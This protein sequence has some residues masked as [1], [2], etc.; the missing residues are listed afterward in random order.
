MN[1]QI[2]SSDKKP[3]FAVIPFDEWQKLQDRL[4]DLEDLADARAL[5]ARI[6]SGEDETFPGEF[7]DRL[8]SGEHPLT[9]W[10]EFRG[11]TSAA[12]ASACG[13][14]GPAISQIE[15]G[16]REPSASLLRRMATALRC[17]MDDLMAAD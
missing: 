11:M 12:L 5:S 15:S 3:Q 8:L 17:S 13:V 7:V 1:V 16:K 6:A 4:E 10:R 14:S 2:I 9:V